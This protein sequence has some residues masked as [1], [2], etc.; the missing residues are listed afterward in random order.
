MDVESTSHLD[1]LRSQS[2]VKATML[3]LG[4]ATSDRVARFERKASNSL[5][6]RPIL[7]LQAQFSSAGTPREVVQNVT[8]Y[9]RSCWIMACTL[10][11]S[12]NS[13]YA[14]SV[15]SADG[16]SVTELQTLLRSVCHDYW[17]GSTFFK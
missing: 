10:S 15:A 13:P 4:V 2:E 9:G 5:Y 12:E 16:V 3:C 6:W 17:Y 1:R 14:I 7:E 8:V 11:P